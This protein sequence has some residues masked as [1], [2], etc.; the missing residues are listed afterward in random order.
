[1]IT[2]KLDLAKLKD[3]KVLKKDGRTFIEV[4]NCPLFYGKNG[5]VYLDFAF[6]DKKND[7]GDDGFITQDLGQEARD[8]GEKGP[9]IGNW[10]ERGQKRQSATS[11]RE[12]DS[13]PPGRPGGSP[14]P[15]D[16]IPF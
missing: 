4:T 14:E 5:A 10:R 13:N 2:G 12:Y 8:R 16:D 9:I 15:D 1:M 7:F 6:H 11:Q 3:A